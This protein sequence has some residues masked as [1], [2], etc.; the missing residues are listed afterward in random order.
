MHNGRRRNLI[1]SKCTASSFLGDKYTMI[2]FWIPLNSC[3]PS[4][5]IFL[6]FLGRLSYMSG[7]ASPTDGRVLFIFLMCQ[8]IFY[9][10]FLR[11]FCGNN[12]LL[13][14]ICYSFYL[15]FRLLAILKLS[16]KWHCGRCHD[17]MLK[18]ENLRVENI[19]LYFLFASKMTI[20]WRIFRTNKAFLGKR[21]YNPH[22]PW[23]NSSRGLW[24]LLFISL[25]I[26]GHSG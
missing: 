6:N 13:L 24:P 2:M 7:W 8:V 12:V 22:Y 1:A 16:W 14:L 23:N 18:K 25:K 5:P 3:F 9:G 4:L 10:V 11:F 19:G 21:F 20:S 26:V 17:I 15:L